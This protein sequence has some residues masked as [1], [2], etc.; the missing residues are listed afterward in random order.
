M[1]RCLS[2]HTSRCKPTGGPGFP[3]RLRG[4]KARTPLHVV[5]QTER[6]EQKGGTRENRK[7]SCSSNLLSRPWEWH[8]FNFLRSSFDVTT[9][10]MYVATLLLVLGSY[11]PITSG[12]LHANG[13][14][15]LGI[16]SSNN[17]PFSSNNSVSLNNTTAISERKAPITVAKFYEVS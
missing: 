14:T 16:G 3:T 13:T 15:P 6:W 8:T 2:N 4:F 7:Q 5:R 12:Q 17:G 1:L 9:S 10:T 11:A